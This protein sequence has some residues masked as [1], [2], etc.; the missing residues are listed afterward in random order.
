VLDYQAKIKGLTKDI[1]TGTASA[2]SLVGQLEE[3]ASSCLSRVADVRAAFGGATSAALRAQERG[4]LPPEQAQSILGVAGRFRAGELSADVQLLQEFQAALAGAGG[5]VATLSEQLRNVVTT[6]SESKVE[7]REA[8]AAVSELSAGAEAELGGRL[9]P[10]LEGV[11]GAVGEATSRASRPRLRGLAAGPI[12]EAKAA[13][14]PRPRV[15]RSV[16]RVTRARQRG[17]AA[18]L[19]QDGDSRTAAPCA[20]R[21]AVRA[22]RRGHPGLSLA[23]PD[24]RWRRRESGRPR[25]RSPPDDRRSGIMA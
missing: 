2:E 21:S 14:R 6:L 12:P 23:A 19:I 16:M 9:V 24:P 17:L 5:E 22:T 18:G 20:Q 13:E 8:R 10:Q 25:L 15:G 7:L 4:A 3:L 11:Q 1:D